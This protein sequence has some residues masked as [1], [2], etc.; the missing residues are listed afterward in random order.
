MEFTITLQVTT[1]T[2]NPL[3]I[4][5]SISKALLERTSVVTAIHSVQIQ[6]EETPTICGY[7][8]VEDP[9]MEHGAVRFDEQRR[10]VVRHLGDIGKALSLDDV[11][12]LIWSRPFEHTTDGSG[13]AR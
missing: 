6:K 8:V 9:S 13:R 3:D 2:A 4:E 12:S 1:N 10:L 7:L 11:R 5:R